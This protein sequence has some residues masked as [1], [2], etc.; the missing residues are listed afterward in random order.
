MYAVYKAK[1]KQSMV[2]GVDLTA[3]PAANLK[4]IYTMFRDTINKRSEH[5]EYVVPFNPE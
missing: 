5:P 3:I 1:M 4:A 2:N